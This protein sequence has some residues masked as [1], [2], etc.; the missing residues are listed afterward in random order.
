M[1]SQ[2]IKKFAS[3]LL[4]HSINLQPNQKIIISANSNAQP[5][6]LELYKQILKKGSYPSTKIILPEMNYTYYKYSSKEQLKNFPKISFQ[7]V[8]QSNAYISIS[9]PS[10]TR[11]LSNINPEKI[12]LRNKTINSISDYIVN[13]KK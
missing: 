2:K 10:N 11:E 13:S 12:T 5:L 6:I 3:I 1:T 7:E 4:N 9:S 8:K